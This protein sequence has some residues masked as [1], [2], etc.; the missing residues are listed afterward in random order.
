L[1]IVFS[2]RLF[3]PGRG[4]YVPDQG[5]ERLRDRP[6][7]IHDVKALS[8]ARGGGAWCLAFAAGKNGDFSAVARKQ[9][10]CL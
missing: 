8:P 3:I 7:A 5:R 6:R 2:E 1:A 10:V 4:T 9:P